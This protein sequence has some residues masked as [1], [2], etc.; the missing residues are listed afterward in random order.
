MLTYCQAELTDAEAIWRLQRL[1]YQSEAQLYG[2]W[3]IPPMIQTLDELRKEFQ[4]FQFLK[5]TTTDGIVGS[6]RARFR[7]GSVEIGRLIVDPAYQRRGIGTELLR[8][9][10]KLFGAAE[11]FELFTG[12]KSQ[13]NIRLYEKNGYTTTRMEHISPTV[14]IVFLEKRIK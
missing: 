5:A 6:V 11:R 8:R 13:S 9:A 1:A 4:Q 12:S 7:R 10:E 2:D 3:S 14:T